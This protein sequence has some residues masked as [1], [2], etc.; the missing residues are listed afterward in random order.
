ML[1][2]K[3][4]IPIALHNYSDSVKHILQHTSLNTQVLMLKLR[5]QFLS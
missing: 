2:R 4:I 1:I 5:R 3:S